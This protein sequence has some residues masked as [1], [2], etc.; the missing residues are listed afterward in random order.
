[1][2]DVPFKLIKLISIFLLFIQTVII[3]CM[4]KSYSTPLAKW[5]KKNKIA[6]KCFKIKK[7]SN[8]IE[9]YSKFEKK[10]KHAFCY[11]EQIL[12]TFN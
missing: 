12:I 7:P 3:Q 4:W 2:N 8:S 5:S 1:M 6:G 11:Y 9:I 10:I